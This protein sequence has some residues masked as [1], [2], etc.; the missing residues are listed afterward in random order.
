[1]TN[2]DCIPGKFYDAGE[3]GDVFVHQTCPKCN[4][5]CKMPETV[6][7]NGLGEVKAEFTCHRCGPVLLSPEYL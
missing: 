3:D 4:A 5:Y 2:R 6:L 7:V 1:M